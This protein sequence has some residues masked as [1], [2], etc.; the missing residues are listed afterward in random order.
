MVETKAE[1]I[2]LRLDDG[3]V[4]E[5]EKEAAIKS[6]LINQAVEE[7][8]DAEDLEVPIK[9]VSRETLQFVI[10]YLKYI[11]DNEEIKIESPLTKPLDEI[12]GKSLKSHVEFPS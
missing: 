2:S 1:S 9:E 6:T 12:L 11:K 5:V 3:Q 4:V 7:D 10:E 8:P